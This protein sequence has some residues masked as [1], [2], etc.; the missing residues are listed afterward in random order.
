MMLFTRDKNPQSTAGILGVH[1]PLFPPGP[2][3]DC[4]DRSSEETD[5]GGLIVWLLF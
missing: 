5:P 3:S 4:I 2:L 1:S